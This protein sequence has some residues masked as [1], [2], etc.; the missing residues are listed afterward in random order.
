MALGAPPEKVHYNPCGVD[1]RAFAGGDPAKA[2]PVFVAAGRFVDK[3]APHL[4][5]LAFAA[6]HRSHP[7]ARLRMIG[8]GPLLA[9]CQDLAKGC[10]IDSAVTFLGAQSHSVVQAEMQRAR[11]FVQHSVEASS[12]DCEGTP[13]S[14]L[15]AGASGLPVISTRHAG[16][17]DVIIEGQTGFLNDEHD[18]DG[19]AEHMRRLTREPETASALGLAARERIRN[20]FSIELSVQQLWSII[21]S[22]LNHR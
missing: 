22:A 17:P 12:G 14:I 19:M 1:Y 18:V 7:E 4:T 2:P 9:A 13:V 5:L 10:G 3:K 15:E 21:E 6:A 8:D 20:N 16:I 11:C